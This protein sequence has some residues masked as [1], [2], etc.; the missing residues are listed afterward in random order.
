MRADRRLLPPRRV[1]YAIDALGEGG[2][3][4][5]L[6]E[7]LPHVQRAGIVPTVAI[8]KSRGAEGVEYSLRKAGI[9]IRVLP[10]ASVVTHVRAL[11][12][13]L[14]QTQP[15]LLHTML[16]RATLVG[17]LAAIGTRTPV[18]TSL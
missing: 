4:L 1:V 14:R 16:Y 9:D 18:L 13:V 15:H 2:T 5:S 3:E 7:L 17:R 11:R 6:A 8:L 10:G 12:R